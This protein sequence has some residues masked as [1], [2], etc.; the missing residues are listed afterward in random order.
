MSNVYLIFL[1]A[2][3]NLWRNK[4]RTLITL[5]SIAVSFAFALVV[6]T[7]NDG[8]H[9][10]LVRN[11]IRLGHGHISVQ[12]RGYAQNPANYKAINEFDDVLQRIKPL[13]IHGVLEPRITVNVLASTAHNSLPA[14]IE[15]GWSDK[16]TRLGV[17][18]EFLIAGQW[19]SKDVNNQ[20][21]IGADMA[22]KLKVRL[23]Q[24]VVFMYAGES[25]DTLAQVGRVKGI[26]QSH[27]ETF[28][29]FVV[30]SNLSFGQKLLLEEPGSLSNPVTRVSITLEQQSQAWQVKQQLLGILAADAIEV[31]HWQEMMPDLLQF[32]QFDDI[33]GYVFLA[34]ILIMVVFGVA[35]TLFM[36]LLQ[37]SREFAL[38]RVIGLSP[39][40]LVVSTLLETIMLGG[41]A[42]A[43]GWVLFFVVYAYFSSYGI[44]LSAAT[45]SS[46]QVAE[47]IMDPIVY[48]ELSWERAV[49]FTSVA[50][51]SI[52]II[53]IY[54]AVRAGKVSPLQAMQS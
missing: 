30:L 34:L 21:I 29:Q 54:P 40:K 52:V 17:F 46:L 51:L 16:D 18:K 47:G 15:S 35:N 8:A 27:I 41:V 5:L 28:D 3:R 12:A 24:K 53:G 48:S 36:S 44:D 39:G 1:L 31:V 14:S 11:G 20:V 19:L 2:W 25:G 13:N 33:A 6:Q 4:R 38:L 9:S 23:G 10:S 42:L 32:I 43:L 50:F 45:E 7:L 22:A 49:Q 26:F 37:R